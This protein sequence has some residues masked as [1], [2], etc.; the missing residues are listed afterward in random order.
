[1]RDAGLEGRQTHVLDVLE[2]PTDQLA[3]LGPA[4]GDREPTVAGDHARD[5]VP[6]RR[7]E[8]RVPEDL[9][10]VV[11]VDV[12]EARR[13]GMPTGVELAGTGQAITDP[14]DGVAGHRDIGATARRAGAV[15]DRAAADDEIR[16]VSL[17]HCGPGYPPRGRSLAG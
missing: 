8:R 15:D 7:R 1:P 13:H 12:D 17:P 16:H 14:G 11:R 9:R 4:R 6:R 10:V 5:A 3:V 2:R